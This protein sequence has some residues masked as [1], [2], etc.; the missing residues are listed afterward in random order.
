[1]KTA[2]PTFRTL[3]EAQARAML[4]RH[5]VG[6]LAYSL[7]DHVDIEPIHYVIDGEWLFGRTSMGTKLSTL[8]HHPW[9]AFEVD[10]FHGMFDWSSV[11]VKGSFHLLD[12]ELGSPDTYARALELV[13]ALIPET[14]SADDPV[15]QRTILF[16]VHTQEITGRAMVTDGE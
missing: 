13:S 7:H 4:A 1:M 5:R 2:A 15:P 8:A 14:F 11:V 3:D 10:E 9:C 12:P 16:G 6:R